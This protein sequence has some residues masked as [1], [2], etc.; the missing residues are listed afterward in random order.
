[1]NNP[2]AEALKLAREAEKDGWEYD[3]IRLDWLST[4]ADFRIRHKTA[5]HVLTAT[6]NPTQPDTPIDVT[7]TGITPEQAIAVARTLR[8]TYNE[9]NTLTIRKSYAKEVLRTLHNTGIKT[10]G[11][12]AIS[13]ES[14]NIQLTTSNNNT[15]PAITLRW[16]PRIGWHLNI[17]TIEQT[18]TH[19]LNLPI[20][21]KPRDIAE[22]VK[23]T[24]PLVEEPS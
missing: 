3:N 8:D 6:Y 14:V 4:E 11:I 24:L 20:L 13:R 2:L 15:T 16:R 7:I 17:R 18:K 10:S 5:G 22:A 23:Q 19:T 1:M 9:N 21:A 12:P